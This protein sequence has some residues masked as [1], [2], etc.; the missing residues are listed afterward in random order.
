MTVPMMETEARVPRRAMVIFTELR[1]D[2]TL[3]PNERRRADFLG[4]LTCSFDVLITHSFIGGA[5]LLLSTTVLQESIFE[6]PLEP[7]LFQSTYYPFPTSL[8]L[9][10]VQKARCRLAYTTLRIDGCDPHPRLSGLSNISGS[11]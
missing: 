4:V 8:I 9:I 3:A 7:N 1:R 10:L 11:R 2:H 5:A 6:G